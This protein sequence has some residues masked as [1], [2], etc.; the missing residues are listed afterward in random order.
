MSVGPVEEAPHRG[1]PRDPR[2]REAILAAAVALVA[3]VG[4]DRMTVDALAA[5]A[6]VSKPTIY[7]RWPGGKS[8]I[9]VE[10]IRA[11]RADGSQAPDTGSLR[12]DLIAYIRGATEGFDPH[13]A[14]GLIMQLQSSPELEQLFREEVVCDE[15]TRFESLLARAAARGELEGDGVVTPL[16]ADIPGSIIFTRSLIRGL[17]ID[18]AFVEELVDR[19]LLP[20]LPTTKESAPNVV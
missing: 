14:A 15:Q 9:I 10:A 4:Y 18:D 11:K 19:V 5:R 6:G 7:R 1:R 13:V 3:E 12:G 2:R 20:I 8:E 17:P 16:F